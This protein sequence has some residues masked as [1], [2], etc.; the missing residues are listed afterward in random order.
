M[1]GLIALAG[2]D[3]FGRGCERMD[4][5]MISATG[6]TSPKVVIAP[7]AA[8]KFRPDMAASNGVGYYN[9]LG[10]IAEPLMVLN[11][12]DADDESL[13]SSI[14][15]A[16]IIYLSGGTPSYLLEVLTNSLMFYRLRRAF[17][18]GAIIAGSSA[19]AMVMGTWMR[20]NGWHQALGL[21]GNVV[22]L[23]HHEN[24]D[25]DTVLKE[26]QGT[27]PEGIV[28]LGIDAMSGCIGT[29][30]EW[31]AIGNGNI[32]AYTASGWKRYSDGE[33]ISL[34]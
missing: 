23:P 13:V 31:R 14:D 4:E 34:S 11:S 20:Y 29:P 6:L 30:G 9:R 7:T 18:R 33:T 12:A 19:G 8:A 17:D 32:T 25:P 27:M 10:A 15:D 5:Q 26:L 24:A 1:A 2:G 3:E 21:S 16:D 28:A 22:S